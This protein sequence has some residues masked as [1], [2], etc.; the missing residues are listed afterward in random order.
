MFVLPGF[1]VTEG[2]SD[3]LQQMADGQG[4]DIDDVKQQI[5]DHLKAPTRRP[6]PS[7]A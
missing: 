5:V 2:A 6:V 4:I 3:P 1:V 7:R